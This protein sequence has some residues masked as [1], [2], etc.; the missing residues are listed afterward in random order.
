MSFYQKNPLFT[1]KR[2]AKRLSKRDI[3]YTDDIRYQKQ[4]LLVTLMPKL[5]A[6]T[7]FDVKYLNHFDDRDQSQDLFLLFGRYLKI[8]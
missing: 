8:S 4:L 1:Q 3:H 2:W 7:V 5:P 6:L